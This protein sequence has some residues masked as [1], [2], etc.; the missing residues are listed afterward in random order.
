[1]IQANSKFNFILG[2][3]IEA[4]APINSK[5]YVHFGDNSKG[6]IQINGKILKVEKEATE[7]EEEQLTEIGWVRPGV[8]FRA[9]DEALFANG[10]NAVIDKLKE[11]N[12]DVEFSIV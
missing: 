2:N 3:E 4:S 12:P 9:D 5:I 8:E 6:K 7:T 11:L 10:H 1:M